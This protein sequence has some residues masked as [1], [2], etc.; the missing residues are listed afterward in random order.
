MPTTARNHRKIK[1]FTILINIF[2]N[3][4]SICWTRGIIP[5]VFCKTSSFFFNFEY[6]DS[7]E[8]LFIE[9]WDTE[10]VTIIWG[11]V[12]MIV[13][14]IHVTV[15]AKHICNTPVKRFCQMRSM[16]QFPIKTP[17]I[18]TYSTYRLPL[19]HALAVLPVVHPRC[20][21]HFYSTLNWNCH[22][23]S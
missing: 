14:K 7:W 19:C 8:K 10:K 21:H 15:H 17:I 1:Y 4:L 23:K 11:L 18:R 12:V 20:I 5:L 13:S 9:F 2:F 6:I 22:Q 3:N 16:V